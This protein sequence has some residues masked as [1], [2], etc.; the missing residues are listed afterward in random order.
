MAKYLKLFPK[1]RIYIIQTILNKKFGWME[2]S[3]ISKQVE[4]DVS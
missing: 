4:I 2:N 3:V 1:I